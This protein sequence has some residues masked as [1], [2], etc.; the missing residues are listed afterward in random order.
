M[1]GNVIQ[2]CSSLSYVSDPSEL[3]GVYERAL[4]A[5]GTDEIAQL[6]SALVKAPSENPPGDV[7][8]AADVAKA[9]LSER[10]HDCEV[11]EPERGRINV[12]ARSGEGKPCLMLMGHID[13]VPAGD[14]ARWSFDPFCGAIR[15]GKVL[16]RGATDM[17]GG[18]ACIMAVYHALSGLM[19]ELGGSLLLALVCDEEIGGRLGAGWLTE[20]GFFDGVD[21]CLISEPTSPR[22]AI[23]GERGICWL[24]LRAHGRSAHG[25]IPSLGQN[26]IEIMMNALGAMKEVE[27]APVKTPEDVRTVLDEVEELVRSPYDFLGLKGVKKALARIAYGV[28]GLGKE[29]LRAYVEACKSFTMNIGIIRGGTKVNIVP[30]ACEAEVDVR[31]PHGASTSHVL[32]FVKRILSDLP[33]RIEV[34]PINRVEPSFTSPS[35][36]ICKALD[37][38]VEDVVGRGPIHALMP[39]TTDG[40]YLRAKGIPTVIYGPGLAHLAHA[41]DEY[42]PIE[43]LELC[44][45]AICLTAIYFVSSGSSRTPL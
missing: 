41:Y 4:R 1:G 7:S 3:R 15:D 39:A 2:V 35:E 14:R 25:S 11:H 33:G 9:W 28:F 18:V 38:A 37:K 21:A 6:C 17:K 24:R 45:R 29:K 8:P 36:A 27:K 13:V 16:G 44:S 31:V 42:V 5:L 34:E 10:G 40:H 30:E 26:A 12:L 19:D 32:S 22:V 20:R 43:H 23:L